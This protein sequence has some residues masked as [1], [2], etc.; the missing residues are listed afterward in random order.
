VMWPLL[1]FGVSDFVYARRRHG[2]CIYPSVSL[3]I[4]ISRDWYRLFVPMLHTLSDQCVSAQ[5]RLTT[6]ISRGE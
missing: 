5:I 1:F 3:D 4:I 2:L 6:I